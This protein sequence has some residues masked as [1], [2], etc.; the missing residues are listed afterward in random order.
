MKNLCRNCEWYDR[1][2][3]CHKPPNEGYCKITK[4]NV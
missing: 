1:F 4:S 2:G 3:K